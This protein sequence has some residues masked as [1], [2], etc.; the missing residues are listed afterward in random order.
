MEYNIKLYLTEDTRPLYEKIINIIK[1]LEDITH[2]RVVVFGGFVRRIFENYFN[3]QKEKD[4]ES[5]TTPDVDIWFLNGP[6]NKNCHLPHTFWER[7]RGHSTSTWQYT[8]EKIFKELSKKHKVDNKEFIHL[9]NIKG[10]NY[11]VVSMTID[12]IKFDMCTSINKF[13][14]FDIISDFVCNNLYFDNTGK[15]F[16]RVKCD[17]SIEEIIE[18]IKNKKLIDII[19][20]D[21]FDYEFPSCWALNPNFYEEKWEYRKNK[22]FGYG[23]NY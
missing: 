17:Y 4:Y 1:E 22:M 21:F 18:Q 5:F 11:S 13:T 12:D 10:I 15:V 23:Y 6:C 14:T 20:K 3:C 2:T 8:S 19:N 16:I 7:P 9:P